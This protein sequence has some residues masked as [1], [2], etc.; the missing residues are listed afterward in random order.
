MKIGILVTGH[1]PDALKGEFD[2]Y[3]VMFRALL[4]GNGFDYETFAVVDNQF[5]ADADQA[6]GWIITGSRHGAYEDHAWIPPLEDLIRAIRDKGAPL[7]GVCFGHQII[8]QALGGTVEKFTGGWAVGRT[9]YD[10]DGDTVTLNAWHQDQVTRLPEGARVLG[11]NDFCENAMVAYGDTIWTV[12]AHPEY[13]DDFITGL[14]HTRG[15]GVVP[16]DLLQD[17]LRRSNT[18]DDSPAIARHMAAFLKKARA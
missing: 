5:P 15:K 13:G 4:D 1:P 14:I 17:A 2:E 7:I 6:D 18:R 9:D 3:D 11:R 12:Q 16:D 10:L 8:A